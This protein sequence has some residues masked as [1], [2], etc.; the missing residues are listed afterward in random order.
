MELG[1]TVV[2][3][4]SAPIHSCFYD[5]FNRHFA[6]IAIGSVD[7]E[8][9]DDVDNEEHNKKEKQIDEYPKD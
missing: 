6:M 3:I 5:V 7:E 9:K 8:K 4:N 1:D 2:L